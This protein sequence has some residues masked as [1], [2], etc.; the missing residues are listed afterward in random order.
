MLFPGRGTF[1]LASCIR[2]MYLGFVFFFSKRL[3][4]NGICIFHN[5]ILNRMR[6]LI[7]VLVWA[8]VVGLGNALGAL[9][10]N[11]WLRLRSFL[12]RR[13][14][15]LIFWDELNG[16]IRSLC[17]YNSWIFCWSRLLLLEVWFC[18]VGSCWL[19]WPCWS[20]LELGTE[21]WGRSL[22]GTDFW[23]IL[24][25]ACSADCCFC[26]WGC[27][28]WRFCDDWDW[29]V[30]GFRLFCWAS[31]CTIQFVVDSKVLQASSLKRK[32]LNRRFD[33]L[34]WVLVSAI[35]I[36]CCLWTCKGC[37]WCI[38]SAWFRELDCPCCGF[39]GPF[40]YDCCC[41]GC[42]W[43]RR[44]FTWGNNICGCSW[45]GLFPGC[46]WEIISDCSGCPW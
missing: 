5:W 10:R 35:S 27:D 12:I 38:G 3:F 13:L 22:L 4:F 33:D 19:A 17:S 44:L 41:W 43:L 28:C 21:V 15:L 6:L 34:L 24:V 40:W 1:W 20:V 2:C 7:C 30:D 14:R 25:S 31:N 36:N 16:S 23:V 39:S 46:F 18:W 9:R 29:F 37:F 42:A 11:I 26:A 32:T 8:L 45:V